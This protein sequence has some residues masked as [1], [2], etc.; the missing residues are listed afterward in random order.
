MEH[1]NDTEP[2]LVDKACPCEAGNMDHV[3]RHALPWASVLLFVR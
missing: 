1:K 3:D 2:E